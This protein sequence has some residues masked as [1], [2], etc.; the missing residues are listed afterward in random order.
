MWTQ[1]SSSHSLLRWRRSVVFF[2]LEL[3]WISLFLMRVDQDAKEQQQSYMAQF[4]ALL[5]DLSCYVN[6]C[7]E[8]VM[9][10]IQQLS[11]L[12][13]QQGVQNGRFVSRSL[14]HSHLL[15]LG[16]SGWWMCPISTYRW[17]DRNLTTQFFILL[18]LD[19]LRSSGWS[20]AMFSH[21]GW[22]FAFQRANRG[23]MAG[24]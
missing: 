9:N 18:D 13:T 3:D 16:L 19:H 17:V 24:I 1:I 4:I 5:Q 6:R 14:R 11:A 10:I 12:Y 15:C 8:V 7:N 22:M 21:S 2:V 23:E 20:V